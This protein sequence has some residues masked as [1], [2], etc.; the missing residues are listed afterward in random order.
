M[1]IELHVRTRASLRPD[2]EFDPILAVFYYIHNDWPLDGSADR[3]EDNTQLG[4]IAIDVDNCGFKILASSSKIKT[5]K[6]KG[7]ASPMKT[8]APA[9]G[10]KSPS[11]SPAK[12]LTPTPSA[13]SDPNVHHYLDGCGLATEIEVNYVSSEVELIKKLVQLVKQV[14]PDFLIGYEI[15]MGSWGYLIERAA[16]LN[17]NLVNEL[18]RMPGESNSGSFLS[19]ELVAGCQLFVLLLVCMFQVL[20]NLI[21][22]TRATM[23]AGK[24]CLM[25]LVGL[26]LVCGGFSSMRSV[27]SYSAVLIDSLSLSLS[28]YLSLS[29]LVQV[30]LNVYSYENVAYHIL[31]QRVPSF[32]FKTLTLWYEHPTSLY[33]YQKSIVVH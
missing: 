10:K 19:A 20:T 27:A 25:S 1:S 5:E 29:S 9:A 18:S 2:P 4:I 33:R 17:T 11:P 28:L 6:D 13:S 26:C 14:D 12:C 8:I 7:E 30:A 15:T 23:T 31:H 21:V 16:Q 22:V 24:L 32:S 3:E